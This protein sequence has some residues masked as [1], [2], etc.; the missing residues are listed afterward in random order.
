MKRKMH[1]KKGEIDALSALQ[2]SSSD[3]GRDNL[4][5]I[6]QGSLIIAN[7]ILPNN[8]ASFQPSSNILSHCHIASLLSK[9]MLN[10]AYEV[11]RF[12]F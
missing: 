10:L 4:I 5:I 2:V 8:E 6:V 12:F 7:I 3:G 1:V 11:F 9:H